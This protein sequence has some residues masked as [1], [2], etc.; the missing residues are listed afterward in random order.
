MKNDESSSA[1]DRD[2][3]SSSKNYRLKQILGYLFAAACLVW[4]FHDI[5]VERL[6]SQIPN[7]QWSLII[8]AVF[9]DIFSYLSQGLR[10]RILMKPLGEISTIK[11]T[12][13]IYAGLFTNEIIPL[14]AG[15]LVRAYLVS[16]WMSKDILSIVP[17]MVIERF[18]D[19]I[20]LAFGIGLTAL[21]V[22][23][24]KNLLKAADILGIVVILA[25]ILFIYLVF[26]KQRE[27]A[28]NKSAVIGKAGILK[29]AIGFISKIAAGIKQIGLKSDFYFA[30]IASAFVLIFQIL[31][32]WLVMRAYGL[33]VSLWAGAAV[34]MIVHLGT[35]IPNAPSNIGSYQ[36]FCVVGLTIFG[37]DKTTATGFSIVVFI[38][39]T[40]PLW[41][42]GLW[43]ISE[44]GM[45]LKDIRLEISKLLKRKIEV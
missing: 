41:I 25:V 19:G 26:R 6:F 1:I 14:R 15:E 7:I 29:R 16:R 23:L 12:Q 22:E 2:R 4:V 28:Q 3:P 30:L 35:A 40:I 11:T 42:L 21:F 27:L 37:I 44:T 20:W 18:H 17:S 43:A 13:A 32:F 38:I 34:M 8:L 5:H 45:K 31:A 36:F 9:F 39:L 24:P 10:W 33:E